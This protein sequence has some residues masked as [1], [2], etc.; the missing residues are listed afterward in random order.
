[1][2]PDVAFH[3]F[4]AKLQEPKANEGFESVRKIDFRFDGAD[5]D[6]KIWGKHWT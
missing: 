1:M 2:L 5:Q 3:T 6:R 4:F